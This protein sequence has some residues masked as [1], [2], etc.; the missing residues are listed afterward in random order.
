MGDNVDNI[1]ESNETPSDLINSNGDYHNNILSNF[2]GN[3]DTQGGD[4]II[5]FNEY[6]DLKTLLL[7]NY[8]KPFSLNGYFPLF[9][10]ESMSNL[11]SYLGGGSGT[12]HTHIFDD[13]T[14][15]MPNEVLYYHGDYQDKVENQEKK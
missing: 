3:I 6:Q 2:I 5:T 7:N 1:L 10:K 9:K 12:S 4:I 14:Y 11:A 13:I 8:E 15:Y